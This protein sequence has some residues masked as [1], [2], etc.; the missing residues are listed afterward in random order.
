MHD[1]VRITNRHNLKELS[2]KSTMT[3]KK[4]AYQSATTPTTSGNASLQSG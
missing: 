1:F 2:G 3:A 4:K